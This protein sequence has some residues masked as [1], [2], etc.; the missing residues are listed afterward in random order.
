MAREKMDGSGWSCKCVNDFDTEHVGSHSVAFCQGVADL[1][2]SKIED[3][4]GKACLQ[5]S[6]FI[7]SVDTFLS[8]DLYT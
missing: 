4:C 7:M 3:M 1:H 2:M 5:L 6:E 8:S